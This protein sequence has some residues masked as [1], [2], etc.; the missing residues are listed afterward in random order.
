MRLDTNVNKLPGIGKARA[1]SLAK[2]G[3]ITIRDLV[4]FYPRAYEYRGDIR[5]L[6]DYEM[7]TPRA[8]MLTV[9]TEVSNVKLKNR[10]TMS[11]FRAF[12]QSGSVEVIFFNSAFVKD[13]FHTGGEFRFFGKVAFS[14]NKR[15]T[16]INP[17]YEPVVEGIPLDDFVP[18]YSITNGLPQKTLEKLI[19]SVLDECIP[20]IED[21]LPENIRLKYDLATLGYAIKHIHTPESY[22]A[23]KRAQRRLAFDEMLLFALGISLSLAKRSRS[24]GVTFSP[25]SLKPFCDLLPYEL[26][27]TQKAAI[28]DVYKD[29]VLK[30]ENGITPA[31]SRIIIGDVGCGKTVCAAA[32]IYLSKCSGYQSALLVPTEILANQHY[33]DM[34]SLLGSLGARVELLT[35][36]TS[37]SEKRRIY[38]GL[39]D[40]SIDVVIG[41]HAIIND[42]LSFASLG[43]IVTDEQHRFG[44]AQRAALKNKS[45]DAHVLVM[46]ATP[47]PRTLALALYGDLDISRITDMPKGRMRVD[48]FVVN[49]GYR[50]RLNSFIEKQVALGGQCY[51]VCPAI[52]RNEDDEGALFVDTFS[53]S[54]LTDSATLNLKNA[55]EHTEDLRRA[56]P[57]LRIE[58]LH[59]KMKKA[60]KDTIMERFASGEIDVLVSTTVIEVG[61]NVPNASL[62]IVENAERFGLSQLHQLRGRVGR[63]QR[64]SYCVLVSDLN[65][66][67]SKARLEVMRTVHDGFEIADKDL[68]LRGPG[69]FFSHNS[70]DNFRQS[71]GFEFKLASMSDDN[72][73]FEAAFAAA[74]GIAAIDPDLTL[75][76]HTA[77]KDLIADSIAPESTIS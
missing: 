10:M 28:N 52:E 57:R 18:R 21:H 17:K 72:G 75:S 26:T 35:G 76:E 46:S 54:G 61:V 30:K 73:L 19:K 36:S 43:L 58:C 49:E 48:T 71:G 63:G 24:R 31:M 68:L 13:I 62:M 44:V 25:T 34:S 32:A 55:T 51:V 7:D 56:L 64:K 40:G 38:A 39:E 77:L 53:D 4:H 11:K 1:E 70:G 15:L 60:E 37:L 33:N 29:T 5:V 66:E 50:A 27:Q 14:K 23:L 59:G 69:D 47:I 22:D 67:K 3:I 12:D 20:Q 41:T 74:K 16:L 8:Y 6:G 2:L 65:T 9:A 42:K 45:H